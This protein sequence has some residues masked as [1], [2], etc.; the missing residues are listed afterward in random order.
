M[1]SVV[2]FAIAAAACVGPF[3]GTASAADAKVAP[4]AAPVDVVEPV[5]L[6]KGMYAGLSAGWT[7]SQ[8]DWAFNPPMIGPNQSFTLSGSGW[9]AD[10]QVGVQHQTNHFVWG[11]EAQALWFDGWA[12]HDGYG[13][14]PGT[15]EARITDAWTVGPRL[16]FAQARHLWY[17]TGGYAH[18][19]VETR[20]VTTLGAL[21]LPSSEDHNGWFAGVGVDW[22]VHGSTVIGLEYQHIA[23]ASAYHCVGLCLLS[24]NNNHDVSATADVISARVSW[25]FR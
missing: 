8:F 2:G 15:A 16:G 18:G 12:A 1:R 20:D 11:L 7:S 19:H 24:S 22:S 25:L 6:W 23:L 4:K 9:E 17:V 10:F 13:I 3:T 21:T 14:S 5:Y